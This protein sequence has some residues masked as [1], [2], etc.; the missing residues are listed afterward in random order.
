MLEGKNDKKNLS[1]SLRTWL[2]NVNNNNEWKSQLWNTEDFLII[3]SGFLLLFMTWRV[4]SFSFFSEGHLFSLLKKERSL[5]LS[6][7]DATP[8]STLIQ[9]IT[10][11]QKSHALSWRNSWGSGSSTFPKNERWSLYSTTF[12][13]KIYTFYN[14]P[15]FLSASLFEVKDNL[16]L[17]VAQR[18]ILSRFV[19][20]LNLLQNKR[21]DMSLS[22]GA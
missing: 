16:V 7:H 1:L 8:L 9:K 2:D 4:V 3:S 15:F 19:F 6:S 11:L 14:L 5:I 21:F 10:Y 17:N 12:F 18:P 22:S 20:S 13:A